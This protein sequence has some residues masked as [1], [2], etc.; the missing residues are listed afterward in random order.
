MSKTASSVR[1]VVLRLETLTVF[2]REFVDDSSDVDR[3]ALNELAKD[4]QSVNPA[5]GRA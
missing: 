5:A 2:L 1:D 3:H 4:G